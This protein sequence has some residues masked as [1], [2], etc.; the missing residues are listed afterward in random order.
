[1]LDY[2]IEFCTL[3]AD[4]GWNQPALTDAFYNGLSETVKDHLTSLDLPS[5][6]DA[7]VSL[8]SRIDKWLMERHRACALQKQRR[9]PP[10]P[11][12]RFQPQSQHLPP[13]GRPPSPDAPEPMQIGHMR[14]SPAE[15]QRRMNEGR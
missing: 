2:A 11:P 15:H 8:A 10:T 4:S 12:Q 5:E 3:A 14:L 1:M 9:P 7:L 13:A 6:L